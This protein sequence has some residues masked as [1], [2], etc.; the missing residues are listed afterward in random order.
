M[1]QEDK[2]EVQSVWPPRTPALTVDVIVRDRDARIAIISRKNPPHGWALPGG[3]VDLEES[4]ETAAVREVA[5]ELGVV[6]KLEAL[7]GV[8]SQPGRDKRMP[9]ATVVYIGR[10]DET[11]KAGSDAKEAHFLDLAEARSRPL[12]F[13]H[14]MILQDYATWLTTG[15]SAPLRSGESA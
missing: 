9:V 5:E 15:H 3:F 2:M 1:A 4:T 13:D 11:L 10:T 14:A 12:A 7:L 6:V 8:Y